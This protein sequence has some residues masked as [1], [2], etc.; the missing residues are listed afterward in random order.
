MK[1]SCPAC[2][3]WFSL[4]AL[5]GHEGAHEAVRLAVELPA[6]IG[7]LLVNYLAC[8][9]SAKTKQ[10]PWEKVERLLRELLICIDSARVERKGRTWPAPMEYWKTGLEAVLQARDAG[11]LA[12]PLP[13]HAYLFEVIARM[14]NRAEGRT[15][16]EN[17]TRAQSGTAPVSNFPTN[18]GFQVGETVLIARG[19]NKGCK[20]VVC[21]LQQLHALLFPVTLPDGTEGT[22][23][24]PAYGFLEAISP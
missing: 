4:D 5:L 8:F 11:T 21:E 7:K 15:E 12:T 3:A 13:D 22:A 10:L 16:S 19:P 9:R 1:L 17:I 18:P 24:T 14:G 6:P 23:M 2:G 20:G